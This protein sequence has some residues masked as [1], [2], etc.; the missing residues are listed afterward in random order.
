[1]RSLTRTLQAVQSLIDATAKSIDALD[2]EPVE[3]LEDAQ[4]EESPLDERALYLLDVVAKSATYAVGTHDRDRAIRV[5]QDTGE[6]IRNPEGDKWSAEMLYPIRSLSEVAHALGC[7]IEFRRPGEGRHMGD[8]IATIGPDTYTR[9]S[10]AAF[11]TGETSVYGKVVRIGGA[12]ALRCG[13]RVPEQPNRMIICSVANQDLAR[14]LGQYL[15]QYLVV[16]GK[17][18]WFRRDWRLRRVDITSY[19]EPKT[20]SILKALDRIHAAGGDA[21]DSIEDPAAYLAKDRD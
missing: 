13:L 12:T 8:V 14:D 5:L 1:M 3:E 20:G 10:E 21:W 16:S 6:A 4:E 11:I 17:A 15:Y 19:E 2:E 7:N 18:T 9:I